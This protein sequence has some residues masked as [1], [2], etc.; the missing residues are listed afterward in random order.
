MD[1]ASKS[2]RPAIDLHVAG[3]HVK[4]PCL[5]VADLERSLRLYRDILGFRLDYVGDASAQ[6]YLYRVFQLPATAQLRFA[7]LSSDRE[8]RA[9]ALSEVKGIKLDPP[10]PPF[11]GATVIQVASVPLLLGEIAA[12]DLQILPPSHFTAPPNLTFTEQGIYDFDGHLLVLY[13]VRP[14]DAVSPV[15]TPVTDSSPP[16]AAETA[17][18]AGPHG[19]DV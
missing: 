6:S 9:L 7:A 13:D 3:L 1:T 15:D 2:D 10:T 8:E 4:R 12:L 18:A 17:P 16:P 14:T 5:L 11:R 19:T